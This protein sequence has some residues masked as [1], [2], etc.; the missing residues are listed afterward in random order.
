MNT[1]TDNDD[2]VVQD[3][4]LSAECLRQNMTEIL[5]DFE[6]QNTDANVRALAH[7]LDD[8]ITHLETKE[9]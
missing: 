2:S 5:Q 4:V 7:L 6:N 8:V 9:P 3:T 1:R